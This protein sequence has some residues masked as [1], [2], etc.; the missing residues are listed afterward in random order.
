MKKK[1]IY[2]K[3]FQSF[4]TVVFKSIA[5]KKEIQFQCFNGVIQKNKN[6]K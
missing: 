1:D 3:F 2:E 4:K 6:K 5:V